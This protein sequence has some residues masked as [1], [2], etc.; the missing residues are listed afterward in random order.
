MITN[1]LQ[2]YYK[3]NHLITHY[4]IIENYTTLS[5]G[6]HARVK[7]YAGKFDAPTP[8]VGSL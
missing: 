6:I 8:A 1:V 2:K 3:S 7:Y 4:L 5:A